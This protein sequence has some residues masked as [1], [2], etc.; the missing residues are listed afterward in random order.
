MPKHWYSYRNCVD[1]EQKKL[2]VQSKPYFM[3]Y[4]YPELYDEYRRYIK[5]T[6]VK[7][8]KLFGMTAKELEAKQ[9]LTEEEVEFLKYYYY[10]F[11]VSLAP[12][13]INRICRYI[14]K[15]INEHYDMLKTQS[16]DYKKYKYKRIKC[17][18]ETTREVKEIFKIYRSRKLQEYDLLKLYDKKALKNSAITLKE[19]CSERIK[20]INSD[21][22]VLNTIIDLIKTNKTA[23][24]FL[25]ECAPELII[26]RLESM[27]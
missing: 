8:I 3:I 20:Q 25:W 15:R 5:K 23:K 13:T 10:F 2:C 18:D 9:E 14:E 6:D 26:D 11:P 22:Q 27:Q 12:S 19:Y 1:D 16:V 17:S 4:R 24:A 21:K 7:C